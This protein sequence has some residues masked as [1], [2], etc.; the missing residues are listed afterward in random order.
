MA[1]RSPDELAA[2]LAGAAADELEPP[3]AAELEA[4]AGADELDDDPLD[5]HPAINAAATAITAP[6]AVMRARLSL[7]VHPAP[8]QR[9]FAREYNAHLMCDS[10]T[11]SQI[12]AA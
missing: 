8:L 7:M 1:I 6:P 4:A 12:G 11:T 5:E 3:A 2:E 10:P 9:A